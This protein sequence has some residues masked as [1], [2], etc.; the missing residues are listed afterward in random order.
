MKKLF[1][2]FLTIFINCIAY[3]Q[4]KSRIYTHAA[5]IDKQV[6]PEDKNLRKGVLDNGLTYYVLPNANG[7]KSV[8]F[9]LLVKAGSIYE[10]ENE[11][12]LTHFVEHLL[13]KGTKH[14]PDSNVY[15]FLKRNGFDLN[16]T[17]RT[18]FTFVDYSIKNIPSKNNLLLDSCIFLFRDFSCDAIISPKDVETERNIILEE[19]RMKTSYINEFSKYFFNNSLYSKRLPIGDLD[20]IKNCSRDLIFKFYKRYYQPQNQAIVLVGDF[21]ADLMVEKIRKMFSNIKR[22]STTLPPLPSIPENNDVSFPCFSSIDVPYY[23]LSLIT[24]I[25]E[26][27]PKDYE[28]VGGQRTIWIYNEINEILNMKLISRANINPDLYSGSSSLSNIHDDGKTDFISLSTTAPTDNWKQSVESLTS[29]IENIRRNGFNDDDI[30]FIKARSNIKHLD[31][32]Y[33]ADTTAIIWKD[34]LDK[35]ESNEKYCSDLFYCFFSNKKFINNSIGTTLSYYLSNSASKYQFNEVFKKLTDDNKLLFVSEFPKN[36][37]FPSLNEFQTVF[38]R[39]KNMTDDEIASRNSIKP[40]KTLETFDFKTVPGRVTNTIIRNDSTN[41]YLLSNGIKV[42]LI[43]SKLRDKDFQKNEFRLNLVRPSGY[44]VLNNENLPYHSMLSSCLKWY[45]YSSSQSISIL[46]FKDHFSS[47]Q[48]Y[49]DNLTVS[50]MDKAFKAIY[51]NLIRTEVD[52]VQFNVEL[53]KI[54]ASAIECEN[55]NNLSQFKVASMFS[56]SPDRLLPISLDNVA[57]LNIDSFK[58]VVNEYH[59]NYNGSVFEAR[60]EFDTDSIMPLIIKY[61]SS[62]PSKPLPV[63][64]MIW[65]ADHFKSVNTTIV[66]KIENPTPICWT[67]LFYTWEKGYKY[68]LE[69]QEFNNAFKSVLYSLLKNKLR[70]EHSDVYS[71]LCTV[72]GNQ[73]PL[74]QMV[75]TIFYSCNPTQRERIVKDVQNIINDMAYGDLITQELIN[76]YIVLYN[77]KHDSFKPDDIINISNRLYTEIGEVINIDYDLSY[78]K[79]LTPNSLKSYIKKMLKK[80]NMHV[81]YLI[82]Q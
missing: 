42:L 21:D 72:K 64:R 59:S 74:N 39:V 1:F 27:S 14:F 57:K 69:N 15:D 38:N 50:D 20:V 34:S 58:N 4:V 61:V 26:V 29:F 28:T 80:G 68:T 52:T 70:V 51:A 11:L 45:S 17:G 36:V 5:E 55:P 24:K 19:S 76:N 56:E 48:F 22:G 10:E 60:G 49:N 44:S 54:K 25:P 3:S 30:N 18:G 13:F 8:D 66:E 12:G 63:K 75:C 33:N 73:Y 71:P 67:F 7:N 46:D 35:Y 81:G 77:K 82:S 2:I 47:S 78:I 9:H 6:I 79:K 62:L 31:A 41:E 23:S 43:K 53:K 37:S 40:I 32:Q 16:Y 65:P